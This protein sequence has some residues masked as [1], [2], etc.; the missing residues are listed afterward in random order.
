VIPDSAVEA[1]ARAFWEDGTNHS[2][3]DEDSGVRG[4]CLASMR[5]A[6]EA[7]APHLMAEA[8]ES[9]WA[10]ARGNYLA[11]YQGQDIPEWV[12]LRNPYRASE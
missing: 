6:L 9:G 5:T 11:L 3:A 8:W 2:W 1:A 4:E 7:A 10:N 12:T